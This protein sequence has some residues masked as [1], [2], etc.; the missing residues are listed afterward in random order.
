[1]SRSAHGSAGIARLARRRGSRRSGLAGAA[2][3]VG[4][5]VAGGA[6]ADERLRAAPPLPQYQ[7]ECTSCH[8]AYPP[9]LLPAVS[10]QR[11]M[12]GL[13]RHYG[14]DASTDAATAREIAS[15]LAVNARI[16][17]RVR[18]APMDDRITRSAWFLREHKEIAAATWK[19]PA[20]GT[21]ANCG[22]CHTQ[23]ERGDFDERNIRIPR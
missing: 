19:L 7:Q 16:G 17:E 13:A 6:L 22:G 4:V 10:W 11:V 2:F 23:A 18:E 8:I 14:V 20:V 15:W 5:I 9:G 21:P 3:A 1:M 12:A